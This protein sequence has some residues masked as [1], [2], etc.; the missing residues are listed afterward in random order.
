M[1]FRWSYFIS[2]MHFLRVLL[3]CRCTTHSLGKLCAIGPCGHENICRKR[4]GNITKLIVILYVPLHMKLENKARLWPRIT[5]LEWWHLFL[6][7]DKIEKTAVICNDK[8]FVL[9][10]WRLNLAFW[11][12][13]I[14]SSF[15]T[16]WQRV[17]NNSGILAN[18][19]LNLLLGFINW[20]AFNQIFFL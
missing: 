8:Q 9:G 15:R 12:T 14:V 16:C 19:T 1:N 18:W 2:S 13:A 3:P 4:K 6:L 20:N 7:R 17:H 11:M 5:K 10:L